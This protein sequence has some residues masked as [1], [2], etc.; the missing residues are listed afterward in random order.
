M[1]SNKA[2]GQDEEYKE[3]QIYIN[4]LL[5]LEYEGLMDE[6]CVFDQIE[7]IIVGVI[8]IF[9]EYH[10]RDSQTLIKHSTSR[11]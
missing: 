6:K 9:Q 11:D 3:P 8:Y 7:T 5:R 10:W 1:K 2:L 4:E